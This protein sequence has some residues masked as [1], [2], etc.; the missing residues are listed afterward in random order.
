MDMQPNR[1]NSSMGQRLEKFGRLH[2]STVSSNHRMGSLM[3]AMQKG[4]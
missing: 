4:G 2:M 3:T 1:V